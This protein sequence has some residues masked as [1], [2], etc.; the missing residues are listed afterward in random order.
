MVK[1]DA[2]SQEEGGSLPRVLPELCPLLPES[3]N[4]FD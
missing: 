1:I 3:L 2:A 4:F